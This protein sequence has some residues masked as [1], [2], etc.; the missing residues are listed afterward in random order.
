MKT[1]SI[2]FQFLTPLLVAASLVCFAG[3]G[4]GDTSAVN[5]DAGLSSEVSAASG[6]TVET[7]GKLT[8]TDQPADADVPVG[9][10]VA[11]QRERFGNQGPV[12]VRGD[13][14]AVNWESL[15]GKTVEIQGDLVVVDTFDLIRRGQVKVARSRLFI[16][17]SYADPNDRDPNGTS[18]TGGDNVGKVIA[19]QKQNDEATVILDDGSAKQN[20]FPPTLFPKLGSGQPTVRVGSVVKGFRGEVV[21]AGR[22]LLLV[23]REPLRWQPAERPARPDV[24]DASVTVASFNVLNYFTTIDNGQNNARGADSRNEFT[25]QEAKIVAAISELK[26]DVVGLMEIENNE[27]AEQKLVRALNEKAG[28][29]VYA[30]CGRPGGFERAYGGGDAIRVGIIYRSDRVSPIGSVSFIQDEAF[31]NA[32]TPLAQDF[33]PTSGGAPFTVVVNH[34][35]S[36]GGAGD[37]DAANKNKGD[38]Q[39]AYNAT[40][41]EQALALSR[42]VKSRQATNSK[43]RILIIGDLNAY[44]QEDPIDALRAGGLVD[45]HETGTSTGTAD[46]PSHYSYIYYGQSGSLDHALATPSLA[47]D[48]TGIATWHINSDEPRFLDYNQEYNPDELYSPDP[49]RS[50]DHDPVLIGIR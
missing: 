27:Q 10:P 2:P 38:G 30:G 34:F 13:L 22:N 33:R 32:R 47:S 39:G 16:P 14:A 12:V 24:G 23:S 5:A 17:T 3:C 40:R 41:R 15:V 36:K 1:P 20:I 6:E 21:K 43:A 4:A 37:A 19:A 48:V 26:A 11:P 9:A 18:F 8:S 44:Q 49:F 46:G 31:A 45:L 25:R 50:S 42:Y 7:P 35:K 29:E 28:A